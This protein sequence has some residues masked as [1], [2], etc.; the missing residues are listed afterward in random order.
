MR[1]LMLE[2]LTANCTAA[3]VYVTAFLDRAAYKRYASE[4][5]W[6][7]EVWIADAPDHLIHLNGGK[8]F[9]PY[10]T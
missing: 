2:Q 9:G 8:F 1:K 6:E 3:I 5:A 4:L 10:E 7:T